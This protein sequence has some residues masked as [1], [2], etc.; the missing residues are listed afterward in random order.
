MQHRLKKY[1]EKNK[2]ARLDD[3]KNA[4]SVLFSVFGRYGDS[5]IAFKVINEFVRMYPGKKY[6]IL[7]SH[8][9]LPYAKSL[10]KGSD[11]NFYSVN[12]RRD[13]I[14]LFRII[15][16]LKK[17]NP[18]IGLN[19]WSQGDDSRFFITFARNFSFFGSFFTHPKEYNL[20]K[21][22]RDYLLMDQLAGETNPAQTAVIKNILISPFSTDVTKSMGSDDLASLLRFVD[23]RFPG[24]DVTVAL[25]K[26]DRHD[27]PQQA[28]KFL[29]GKG[30]RSSEDFLRLLKSSDL[31]IGVDAGP[32]HLADAIGVKSIGI[33]GPTAPETV[34]DRGSA[35]VPLRLPGLQNIFCFVRECRN[36]LCIHNLLKNDP[37]EYMT[38]MNFSTKPL[39][40]VNKCVIASL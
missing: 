13:P 21:T 27:V 4:S 9:T 15:S 40:E 34:L 33:F 26:S 10:I 12:K 24:A 31:F 20:Y 37:L 16:L 11:V 36:P 5:I 30:R 17:E 39:L 7:T 3:I 32:L 1:R 19:P 25:Q 35:V 18:D 29:F 23:H 2:P 6:I 14:R 28:Q 8:Q 22:A 38:T